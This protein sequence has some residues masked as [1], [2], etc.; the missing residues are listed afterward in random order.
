MNWTEML[1]A[2]A[3]I[4]WVD[5]LLSGDN[6]IVI[7]M[8]CRNLGDKKTLGMIFGAGA[9]VILRIACTGTVAWLMEL[10]YL[11]IVGSILLMYVAVKMVVGEDD[12]GDAPNGHE[13]LL[14]A[15]GTIVAA[16]I[17]MSLDNVIAVAAA[18]RGHLGLMVFGL[19]LSIPLIVA[20]ASV[21][22]VFLSKWP[23]LIWIGGALLGFIA[24][25]MAISDHALPGV[26]EG[27]GLYAS[28]SGAIFV[29]LLALIYKSKKETADA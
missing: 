24:G 21:I 3:T 13:A 22:S 26:P 6:A 27:M 16:D 15:V 11:K 14:W 18:A 20:G 1:L 25:D 8:A 9:A 29:T 10:P 28:I 12:D 23:I 4:V 7:A 17:V 5:V 19:C 2:I